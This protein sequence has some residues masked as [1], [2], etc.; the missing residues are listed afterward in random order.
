MFTL[1]NYQGWK[2]KI[3]TDLL[4]GS[5]K[6][7][8]SA[9]CCRRKETEKIDIQDVF[10]MHNAAHPTADAIKKKIVQLIN[11]KDLHGFE[12]CKDEQNRVYLVFGRYHER[13]V[14]QG[15]GLTV[16]LVGVGALASSVN[17]LVAGAL[18]NYGG[19]SFWDAYQKNGATFETKENIKE[20]LT[21]GAF[22]LVGG[23]TG[24]CIAPIANWV[25]RVPN[26]TKVITFLSSKIPGPLKSALAKEATKGAVCNVVPFVASKVL[27]KEKLAAS[28]VVA[29]IAA[30]SIPVGVGACVDRFSPPVSPRDLYR[31][32]AQATLKGSLGGGLAKLVQDL[33]KKE[34][35]FKE[36]LLAMGMGG[37]TSCA[38][39]YA[40]AQCQKELDKALDSEPMDDPIDQELDAAAD[41]ELDGSLDWEQ[42]NDLID[43]ELDSTPNQ[44]FD[45]VPN[46]QLD[47][48][49]DQ[50][51]KGI[52]QSSKE[53]LSKFNF[54]QNVFNEIESYL[55]SQRNVI[56]KLIDCK[57][58]SKIDKKVKHGWTCN[59]NYLTKEAILN[60]LIDGV[61][62]IMRPCIESKQSKKYSPG[63]KIKQF[64]KEVIAFETAKEVY[65]SSLGTKDNGALGN[66][67]KQETALPVPVVNQNA[68]PIVALE[69]LKTYETPL[70]N[71]IVDTRFD[72]FN[73]PFEIIHIQ[74]SMNT[75]INSS[76]VR[77]LPSAPVVPVANSSINKAKT[78]LGYLQKKHATAK[79]ERRYRLGELIDIQK[80]RIEELSKDKL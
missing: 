42:I 7:K 1:N 17:P 16:F 15:M 54:Y 77:F 50:E 57:I 52:M 28:D 78:H 80:K 67:K 59:G 27:K 69:N 53:E 36:M 41:Q 30:G 10:I 48:L 61:E 44:K 72:S 35:V 2:L 25:H 55:S 12:V 60:L 6:K 70:S 76:L 11:S 20:G 64:N 8:T 23:L 49:L 79:R 24:L 32:C 58:G 13:K 19:S 39:A 62:V 40:E 75:R 18:I 63:S 34:I 51:F 56:Y 3:N 5:L 47:S 66:F 29:T 22:A 73:L 74:S 65:T 31:W 14:C 9:G 21:G 71:P 46:Q 26:V 37:L 68:H 43:Q 4:S 38:G 33:P 45:D